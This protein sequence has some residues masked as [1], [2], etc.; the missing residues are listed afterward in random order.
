[1]YSFNA[2]NPGIYYIQVY[3]IEVLSPICY[4]YISKHFKQSQPWMHG[5]CEKLLHNECIQLGFSYIW[6]T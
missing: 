5:K 6:N 2:H 1:M 4:V 3:V